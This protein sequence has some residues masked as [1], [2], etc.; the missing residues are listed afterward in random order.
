HDLAAR[1]EVQRRDECPRALPPNTLGLSANGHR[2][3]HHWP[4]SERGFARDHFVL[5]A[6]EP[7]PLAQHERV[8]G[9]SR[10]PVDLVGSLAGRGGSNCGKSRHPDYR[11][12]AR[13]GNRDETQFSVSDSPALLGVLLG[14]L[15]IT[16]FS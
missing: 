3:L 7:P 15:E 2:L 9:T 12:E 13:P 11:W 4:E 16:S 10:V 1:R 6:Q 5:A 14:T 8:V